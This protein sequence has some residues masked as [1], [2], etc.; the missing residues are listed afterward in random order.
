MPGCEIEGCSALCELELVPVTFVNPL[1][2]DIFPSRSR[3]PVLKLCVP[4]SID[5]A[6]KERLPVRSFDPNTLCT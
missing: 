6:L 4:A 1:E 5:D 3:N 2:Y